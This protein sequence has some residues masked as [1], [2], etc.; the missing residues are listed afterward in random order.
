M[1]C[2]QVGVV[3]SNI[4]TA[5]NFW[6]M[7]TF[8]N[9]SSNRRSYMKFIESFANAHGSLQILIVSTVYSIGIGSVLGLVRPNTL[10]GHFFIF[11]SSPSRSTVD[12]SNINWS[13]CTDKSWLYWPLSPLCAETT[14]LHIWLWG[15][16]IG[17]GVVPRRLIGIV[18][19]SES[20]Y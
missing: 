17:S 4:S 20:Y 3:F 10:T 16:S 5:T 2:L 12:S 19:I 7:P 1:I 18:V 14:G 11:P 15:R 9:I 13:I 6:I 8:D